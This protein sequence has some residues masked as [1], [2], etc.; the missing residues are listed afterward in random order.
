MVI[1]MARV[2]QLSFALTLDSCWGRCLDLWIFTMAFSGK[3]RKTK[4]LRVHGLFV[5]VE[6]LENGRKGGMLYC[7]NDATAL[8]NEFCKQ[9]KDAILLCDEN[10]TCANVLQSLNKVMSRTKPGELLILFL[11]T[12]GV[13]A[14][15]DFFLQPYDWD[16]RNV[17]GS[18]ISAKLLINAL[19]TVAD[20]GVKALLILDTCHGGAIGFDISKTQS[21]NGGGISCLFSTSPTEDRFESAKVEHGN[22]TYYLLDG[23]RG[24]ADA[25]DVGVIT[26]RNL[27]DHVYGRT[28]ADTNNQQNPI[29]I[30]TLPNETPL[31][32]TNKDYRS[33]QIGAEHTN[34]PS[35]QQEEIS[36]EYKKQDVPAA[37]RL[38]VG[39]NDYKEDVVTDLKY[40]C[41]DARKM[42]DAFSMKSSSA[43]GLLLDH[44]ATRRDIL[45]HLNLWIDFAQPGD[46]IIFF[47]ATHGIV[48][49]NDF[50]FLPHDVDTDNLLGT[51]IPS[52][53][54]VNALASATDRGVQC[55]L[56]FD[57]CYCGAIGFDI[58]KSHTESEGGLSCLYSASP[59][60]KSIEST[61]RKQGIFSHFMIQG[62]MGKAASDKD[63][64]VRLRE[65]YDFVY[66]HTKRATQ[67]AQHPVLIGT[68]DNE[69]VLFR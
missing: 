4:T 12:R 10:A 9:N 65:L 33:T 40:C 47:V 53:M 28:K 51:G 18:G 48:Q 43:T 17:L 55:L 32:K 66:S 21:K 14:H 26:L 25:N 68:L 57:S 44:E 64:G 27:Y 1:A 11:S 35:K 62:L 20:K 58:S 42:S 31:V 38:F 67:Q 45:G 34:R 16:E 23:L 5:G 63:S 6:N 59:L 36:I 52:K 41:E 2:R 37:F 56:I 39:V 22:F 29:L 3:R 8:H 24:G 69:T 7:N 19:G 30:G 49:F 54:I 60:E 50:F 13:V 61:S 15:N 46:L